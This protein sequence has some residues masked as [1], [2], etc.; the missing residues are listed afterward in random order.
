MDKPE[1]VGWTVKVVTKSRSVIKGVVSEVNDVDCRLT[2]QD[3]EVSVSGGRSRRVE[4]V[5]VQGEDIVDLQVVSN[6]QPQLA[7]APKPAAMARTVS[8]PHLTKPSKPAAAAS[9]W[10]ADDVKE[11]KRTEFDIQANLQLF[12]KKKAFA[13]M[14]GLLK[15]ED[16]L[17]THNAVKPPVADI[18]FPAEEF[19]PTPISGP[20]SGGSSSKKLAKEKLFEV[21]AGVSES[22]GAD[23]PVPSKTTQNEKKKAP[24][25][26]VLQKRP[27]E[28]APAVAVEERREEL[29][30][31][32]IGEP[33]AAKPS[34]FAVIGAT[35]KDA[36]VPV[37]NDETM[38]LIEQKASKMTGPTTDQQLEA[39]SREML[40]VLLKQELVGVPSSVLLFVGNH[41]EGA[42]ALALGR[43]LAN[44]GVSVA[45]YF[46]SNA[47]V[48]G[49]HVAFQK[50]LFVS[51]GGKWLGDWGETSVVEEHQMI[52]DAV[53]GRELSER[54][55]LKL[56][57]GKQPQQ[58]FIVAVERPSAELKPD[59]CFTLAFPKAYLFDVN[60]PIYLVDI[61]L[62][63]AA[64][65]SYAGDFD[66]AAV[67]GCELSV[68]LRRLVK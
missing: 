21:P 19:K 16:L 28:P 35:A 57:V 22:K 44:R 2:L 7:T 66:P 31:L 8:E 12:D 27:E 60:C 48:L 5:S 3:A 24:V 14:E 33:I 11:L 64:Y 58:P 30:R 26:V 65:K 37:M 4:L 46:V 49:D 20:V 54:P 62:P 1:F 52:V 63:M 41:R 42:V 39:A 15:P 45:A 29:A 36:K 55:S 61:N 67:Y 34:C 40:R 18:F 6:D 23:S 38:A 17:V 10:A 59:V 47:A 43:G 53:L 50:K 13:G 68:R 32:K 51:S 56:D 9:S 25:K